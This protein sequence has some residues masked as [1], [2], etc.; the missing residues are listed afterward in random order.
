MSSSISSSAQSINQASST[1]SARSGGRSRGG[2]RGGPNNDHPDVILSKS[3][4]RILRH[5]AVAEG[6]PIRG[7]GFVLITDLVRGLDHAHALFDDN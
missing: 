2:R 5:Q 1:S 3:L 4:S 7:D 6:I